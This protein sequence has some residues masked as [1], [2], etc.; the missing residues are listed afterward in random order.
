MGAAREALQTLF[1]ACERQSMLQLQGRF[2]FQKHFG[3]ACLLLNGI[4]QYKGKQ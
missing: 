1:C 2:L 3:A 4:A